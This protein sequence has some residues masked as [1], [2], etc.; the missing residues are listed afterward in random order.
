M[1]FDETLIKLVP[2]VKK[3]EHVFDTSMLIYVHAQQLMH[4]GCI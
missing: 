2:C 3:T 1:L 4:D